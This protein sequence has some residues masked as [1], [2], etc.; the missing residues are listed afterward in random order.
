MTINNALK[1]NSLVQNGKARCKKC[2]KAKYYLNP[3]AR[4]YE[5]KQKYC[6]DHIFSG[7]INNLMKDTDEIRNI[8]DQCR[9]V[10]N[11][12]TIK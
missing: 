7:Q 6:Y 3:L 1:F 9:E 4:C 8:C 12:Q 5:C 11:Y 10:N 2:N